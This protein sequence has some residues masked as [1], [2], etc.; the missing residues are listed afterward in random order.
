MTVTAEGQTLVQFR[1]VDS[2]GNVSAWGPSAATPGAT[3]RI[4]RTGPTA[5][6]LTGG[7]LAWQNAPSVAVTGAGGTDA[8]AGVA[9]YEY[10]TSTDGGSTWS[11]AQAGASVAVTGEGET[12][13]QMRTVDAA[14]N[15]SA[16]APGIPVAGSTV[17]LDRGLP[18]APAV[19]GGSLAWQ[20]APSVTVSA[21]GGTDSGSG[22]AGYEYRT[23][24]DGGATWL[25]PVSGAA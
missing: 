20:S 23:S 18:T 11:A 21:A 12:L 10:R 13:V 22:V 7:S 4:D 3:V 25:S 8:L 9:S 19:S 6:T 24:T 15:S 5:P 17:R 14:G 2:L 16:W 1:S